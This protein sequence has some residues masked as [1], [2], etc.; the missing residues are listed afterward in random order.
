MVTVGIPG[1]VLVSAWIV[2]LPA[3]HFFRQIADPCNRVLSMLFLRV[4]IFGVYA[5]CF[6]STLFQQVGEVWFIFIIAVF[7]L[8]QL[9]VSR[10]KL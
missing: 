2:F 7:G 4:W 6:E 1:L 3:L 9:T 5:S 10:V 8:Q